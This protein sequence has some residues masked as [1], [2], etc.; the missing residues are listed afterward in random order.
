MTHAFP[1]RTALLVAALAAPRLAACG[2]GGS[3]QPLTDGAPAPAASTAIASGFLAQDAGN[4]E[5]PDAWT[6]GGGPLEV[7]LQVNGGGAACG[8][9]VVVLAQAFGAQQPYTYAWS[10]SDWHGP[11][12]FMVCATSS[13]RVAVEV[14]SS[15]A[16]AGEGLTL[17]G[18]TASAAS[19]IDCAVTDAA[20][21]DAS[22]PGP[23]NGCVSDLASG[24]GGADAGLTQCPGNEID[25]SVAWLDGG[26]AYSSADLLPYTLLA[27]HTYQASYD[28]LLPIEL[29][30]AVT[31]DVYGST[32]PDV[33][34]ADAKLFTLVLN[35]SIANWHQ[36]YCFTPDRDYNYLV[37]NIGIQGVLG[38]IPPILAVSTFCDTCSG[39]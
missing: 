31:V 36:S 21:N 16:S 1:R 2:G 32:L 24:D 11:G 4:A 17:P 29:G 18:Q 14:T 7:H 34:V 25:A 3:S 5:L 12:P 30:S 15:P 8:S 27:G 22:G 28:Q 19:T 10:N 35:G 38:Y 20:G 6:D 33:C 37:E 39:D 26:I 9:C 13:T 23:L